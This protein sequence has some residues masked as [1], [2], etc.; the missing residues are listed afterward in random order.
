MV[1]TVQEGT[2]SPRCEQSKVRKVQVPYRLPAAPL[3]MCP[4]SVKRKTGRQQSGPKSCAFD[5]SVWGVAIWR[6][7]YVF[8][9]NLQCE[10][11]KSPPEDLW[12]YFQ[13]GLEFFNQILHAYY[14]F[15]STLDYE[16]L[17]KHL[18]VWRNYAILSVT[19][20]LKSCA[21]N[22]HHQPKRIFWHFS[23]RVLNF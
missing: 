14:A 18:Q 21:Q 3:P 9:F 4:S 8:N 23:Q 1:R 19:T 15:L 6:T 10:S 16:F 13:N 5:Y 22:V 7:A 11:K 20:Q 17:F 12:Q 2:N